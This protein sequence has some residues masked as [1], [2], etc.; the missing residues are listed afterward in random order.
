MSEHVLEMTNIKKSFSGNV[1]LQ[2]VNLSIRPG[3]VHALLGENGAGKST[4]MKILMG[5]YHKDEGEIRLFGEPVSINSPRQALEHGIAM[6]HQELNPVLDMTLA[7]NVFL[8][9]ESKKLGV[10]DFKSM[11][12]KTD[13]YLQRVGLDMPSSRKMRGLNVAQM[14]MVEIAK[15]ISWDA[16]L[17][18]MDEPTASLTEREVEVLFG[19]IRQLIAEGCSIIYISHKMDEIFRICDRVTVLRNGEVIG[20]E[21]IATTNQ[22]KLISMMVGREVGEIYP[23]VPAEIGETVFEV[24]GLTVPGWVEDVSFNLRRG[25]ILGIAGLVG[26]GR[27]EMMEALFGL[28]HKTEGKTLVN[29]T[30]VKIHSPSAAIKHKIAFVTEDRKVTGLNLIGSVRENMTVVC[31]Q[32]LLKF[33]ML[34]RNNESAATDTYID[35]LKVKTASRETK[36]GS[37]SGGNQQKVAIAK[38]LLNEPDI[39]IM[40]EPTRGI[41]VGA[42]RDIYV[43]MGE[44]V[45]AGKAVLM[46]SSEMPEVIGMS[47][48]I[49]VLADG[50][51]MGIVD[52]E[53]FDQ[54]TLMQMQFGFAA[55]KC[56]RSP[57]S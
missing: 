57:E 36:V 44:L 54:D 13:E 43:L 50:K 19:I 22:D 18:I 52:R 14:Q 28:R 33:G 34:N 21:E 51:V 8:G 53:N 1:V 11:Q 6:I 25:E 48:R 55:D 38:W 47:D 46:I 16:K 42:K 24:Q 10:L 45:Q 40:D 39:I 29:G 3:E 56:E 35:R 2:N 37:L 12:K 30:E 4:L 17:F 26:A 41:D 15:A 5:I 7:E 20:T 9:K 32:S 49:M 23:K 31:I 27:S